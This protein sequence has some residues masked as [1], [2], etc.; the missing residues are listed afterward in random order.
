VTTIKGAYDGITVLDFTQGI[1][2]PHAS[3]L[4]ALHG[5]P[6]A[7]ARLAEPSAEAAPPAPTDAPVRVTV[8]TEETA[9]VT[10]PTAPTA[11]M[12]WPAW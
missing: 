2:G 1:A 9:A 4:L 8:L 12:R 3:M 7:W 10:V 11:A 6:L 5:A